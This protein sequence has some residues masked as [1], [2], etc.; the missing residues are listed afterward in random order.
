MAEPFR[1]DQGNLIYDIACG[2]IEDA[3]ALAAAMKSLTGVVEH[4]LFLDLADQALVG[5]DAGATSCYRTL[6]FSCLA[7]AFRG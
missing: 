4:G 5:T 3:A 7:G 6:E 1:T 2:R